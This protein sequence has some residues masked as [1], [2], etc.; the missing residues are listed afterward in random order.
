MLDL[1]YFRSSTTFV[2]LEAFLILALE[3]LRTYKIGASFVSYIAPRHDGSRNVN[4]LRA[5][6]CCAGPSAAKFGVSQYVSNGHFTGWASPMDG[7]LVQ[8]NLSYGIH[9]LVVE[10]CSRAECAQGYLR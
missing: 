2:D 3:H 9:R 7:R 5:G 6:S 8:S 10:G 4:L 1:S